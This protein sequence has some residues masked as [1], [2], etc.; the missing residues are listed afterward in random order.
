LILTIGIP[1]FN[2]ANLLRRCLLTLIDDIQEVKDDV[3]VLVHDNGSTD[4]TETVV[5]QIISN[6]PSI[7]IRYEK[8]SSNLGSPVNILSC[9]LKA[10]T[11][12]ALFIGDDDRIHHDILQMYISMLKDDHCIKFILSGKRSGQK[13]LKTFSTHKPLIDSYYLIG[14]G[15]ELIYSVQAIKQTCANNTLYKQATQ[16]V[17]SQSASAVCSGV[18][19]DKTSKENKYLVTPYTLSSELDGNMKFT[20][21]RYWN[22]CLTDILKSYKVYVSYCEKLAQAPYTPSLKSMQ[23]FQMYKAILV[24]SVILKETEDLSELKKLSKDLLGLKGSFFSLIVTLSYRKEVM[25]ILLYAK[26]VFKSK[27]LSPSKFRRYVSSLRRAKL[28]SANRSFT[29]KQGEWF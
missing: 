22:I 25:W 27:V 29:R 10:E 4:E 3:S 8:N 12:Y 19:L 14:N 16:T 20:N 7:N 26:F 23:M 11:E 1:T 28:G 15:A 2:R 9:F 17:W 6:N 24:H 21:S 18:R 13:Q 5:R